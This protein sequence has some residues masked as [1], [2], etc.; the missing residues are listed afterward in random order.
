MVI[1]DLSVERLLI[2]DRIRHSLRDKQRVLAEWAGG[3]MAVSAVPGAGK[4]TGMAGGAAVAIAEHKLHR[5]KQLAIV[6]FTRSAAAQIRDK[7][8]QHLQ[9]LKLPPGSFSVYTIHGLS[10]A[11]AHQHPDLSGIDEET[12]LLSDADKQRLIRKAVDRWID[13]QPR[14]FQELLEGREFDGEESERQRRITTLRGEILPQLARTLIQEA[15]SS[16]CSP[17]DLF[18]VAEQPIR[19][20]VEEF[21]NSARA[22]PI[23]AI[24]AGLYRVYET[25]RRE[26]RVIDYDDM[27]RAAL[28]V[29]QNPLVR[30]QWQ[31]QIFAVFEDEA[32][33]SSLQQKE[34]LEQLAYNPTT[35]K[36]NFVRVGDPNQAINS[37]FTPADPYF[38][39]HFCQQQQQAHRFFEMTEAGRSHSDIIRAANRV[40][41]AA[42]VL[43]DW[44]DSPPFRLQD[45]Q[46]VPADDPQ[47][48]ANPDGPGV[49]L[50]YPDSIADEIKQ[51]GE[52]GRELLAQQP[53]HSAAILVRYKAQ[54]QYVVRML[55]PLAERSNFEL[56]DGGQSGRHSRVPLELLTLAQFLHRPHS[57]QYARAALEVLHARDRVAK[58]DFSRLAS[59][60]ECFLYPGPL[61]EPLAP[62]ELQAQR[63]CR[64]LLK[65]RAELPAAALLTFVALTLLYDADELATTDK[66]ADRVAREAGPAATL[67]RAVELLSDIV[68]DSDFK[69]LEAGSDSVYTRAQ[70]LTVMTLH[71]AKGL[72]WDYVFLPFLHERTFPG[73]LYVPNGHKFL[74]DFN[75]TDVARA[76]LRSH[77][78]G[79]DMPDIVTAQQQAGQLKAAEELRLL[80]VGM[81]RAKRLLWLSAAREAP[82][83][84]SVPENL[85]RQAPCPLLA[86]IQPERTE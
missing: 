37:T 13:E 36:L 75:V 49:E 83:T 47:L 74:G 31:R 65:A 59:Q 62:V 70:Q 80:Y 55:E 81:T 69:P 5:Q 1:A 25:M 9:A 8:R 18:L 6:T 19:S 60:P 72:D 40:L 10:L 58:L 76:Q 53:K 14:L 28:R 52:R 29:L 2:L 64:S 63:L 78:H 16:E 71:S 39:R 57:P 61:A 56:Y 86:C 41:H 42:N 20:P 17:E 21:D 73:E 66:L 33:D 68:A 67:G 46:P 45:I 32:Q 85:S 50:T 30:S 79:R 54:V 34:L 35:E 44:R 12:T 26:R 11:I 15:K 24:A 84:W 51:M 82:F 3:P 4:S 23:L 48:D 77:L 43:R 22:Y 7:V 27:T 38:F